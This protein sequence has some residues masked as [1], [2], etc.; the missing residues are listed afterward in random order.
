M[1]E[2]NMNEMNLNELEEVSGGKKSKNTI[3]KTT[4]SVNVRKG[5]GKDYAIMGTLDCGVM[6]SYLGSK[7]TDSRGVAWYKINYNGQVGWVSSKYAK[8]I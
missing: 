5:P 3:V 4:G 2:Q 6:V 1:S 7:K 8:L